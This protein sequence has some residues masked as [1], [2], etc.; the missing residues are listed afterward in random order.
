MEHL[1]KPPPEL[2][3]VGKGTPTWGSD[4][5]N[6]KTRLRQEEEKQEK[7]SSAPRKDLQKKC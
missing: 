4:D 3:P 6:E 5:V 7:V 1:L 2:R